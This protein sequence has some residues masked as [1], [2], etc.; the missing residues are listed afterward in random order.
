VDYGNEHEKYDGHQH[1]CAAW[2]AP[3]IKCTIN[4][5]ST[6]FVAAA[7]S[8]VQKRV[9]QICEHVSK[10]IKAMNIAVRHPGDE[11]IGEL[12][13]EIDP[14]SSHRDSIECAVE[15]QPPVESKHKKGCREC[16]RMKVPLKATGST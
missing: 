13:D 2:V 10:E 14:M 1:G 16:H 15:H 6:L 11:R 3:P 5:A 7:A 9:C 12:N 4:E 8:V